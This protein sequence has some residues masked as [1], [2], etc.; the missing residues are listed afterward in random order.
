MKNDHNNK[1]CLIITK[2]NTNII[3]QIFDD[4]KGITFCSSSSIQL[5][6]N[7]GNKITV[8]K[9]GEDISKNA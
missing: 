3:L 7:S 6:L 2:T 1:P 4:Q 8:Q 5:K 9:F